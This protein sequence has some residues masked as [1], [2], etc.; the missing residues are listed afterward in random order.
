MGLTLWNSIELISFP[1]TS[2]GDYTLSSIC[3]MGFFNLLSPSPSSKV[4]TFRSPGGMENR[5]KNNL[6][7]MRRNQTQQQG[8]NL[9]QAWRV[10]FGCTKPTLGST[11]VRRSFHDIGQEPQRTTTFPQAE[12]SLVIILSSHT[13]RQRKWFKNWQDHYTKPPMLP[14]KP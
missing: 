6:E 3:S 13:F 5:S 8:T 11:L 14:Y 1:Y 9:L 7:E 4:D 2:W 12:S 10:V